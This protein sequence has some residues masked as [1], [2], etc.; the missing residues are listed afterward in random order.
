MMTPEDAARQVMACHPDEDPP[1]VRFGIWD[2]IVMVA[3]AS[4]SAALMWWLGS[5]AWAWAMRLMG[6]AA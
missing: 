5:I 1:R 4:G 6:D 2:R 3:V